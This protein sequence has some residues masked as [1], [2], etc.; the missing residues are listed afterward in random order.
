MKIT[1]TCSYGR[2]SLIDLISDEIKGI[3]TVAQLRQDQSSNIE[4]SSIS[5]TMTVSTPRLENEFQRINDAINSLVR[6]IKYFD[7]KYR[8]LYYFLIFACF[9]NCRRINKWIDI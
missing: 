9:H 2:L 4:S 7:I 1:G 5:D 3:P 6:A 8:I